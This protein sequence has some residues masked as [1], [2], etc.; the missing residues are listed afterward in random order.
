MAE[1]IKVVKPLDYKIR[2]EKLMKDI[3]EIKKEIENK[4]ININNLKEKQK[5]KKKKKNRKK[6]K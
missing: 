6:K 5:K 2:N 4:K 3:D 1:P